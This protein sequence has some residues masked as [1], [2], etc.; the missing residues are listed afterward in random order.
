MV[1]CTSAVPNFI[2]YSVVVMTREIIAMVTPSEAIYFDVDGFSRCLISIVCSDTAP[3]C[4]SI[5][6]KKLSFSGAMTVFAKRGQITEFIV[7]WYGLA[8]PSLFFPKAFVF[9]KQVRNWL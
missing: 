9:T 7:Q 3:R 6:Y 2:D 4:V 5:T 8:F 1:S